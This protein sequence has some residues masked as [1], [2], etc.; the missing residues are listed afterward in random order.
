MSLSISGSGFSQPL[1]SAVTRRVPVEVAFASIFGLA[2]FAAVLWVPAVLRDADTLWHITTGDWILAHL[3]V[4]TV[5][6]FSF[7]AAG[8]PWEAQEWLSEVIMAL[9]YRMAG[10]DGLMV[11]T[12]AVSGATVGIVAFYLRRYMRI[13]VAVMFVLLTA[14]CGAPSLLSRPHLIALPLLA[15]WTMSLV[16][17]RAR[18]AAPSLLLLPVMAV[19]A[20]LHGGFLVGLVLAGALAVEAAFDPACRPADSIRSW[21]LFLVGAVAATLITPH[22]IDGLL[23]PFRLMSMKSLYSIQEWKPIDL[24]HLTGMTVAILVALYVGLT[25]SIRLPRFRVLLVTGLIFSTMQH[26]RNA[27]VFAVMAPLLIANGLGPARP[28]V[29][30]EWML[31][32]IVGLIAVAS[33]CVRI[34]FPM[35]RVDEGSYATAAL[36]SVPDDLRAKPVLNDYGFGGLMIFSGIKPFIDGRA[37]LYG[38]K[39]MERYLSI[40][41]ANGAVLDDVL[42]R[43]HIAWTIF[44]PDTVV[45]AL[46]DRTAGW[47]RFYSDKVAVI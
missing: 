28:V 35:E 40:I 1:P 18:G 8:R 12:A 4:P 46:M 36:A 16:S 11:L 23:F 31:G 41:H 14:A 47:H 30:R 15:F 20:N 42:C 10:W 6:T 34:G 3:A 29:A 13:D 33:L 26:V 2:V 37:D 22:G 17:A 19:W 27:Q 43:Y 21:G 44:P 24:S 5:D 39:G 7:T 25:G 45:T 32:G 38:E 9:A